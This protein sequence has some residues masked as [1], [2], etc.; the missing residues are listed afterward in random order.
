[1]RFTPNCHLPAHTLL[2]AQNCVVIID[3]ITPFFLEPSLDPIHFLGSLLSL[4]RMSSKPPTT[5]VLT[6]LAYS[7]I[8]SHNIDIPLP[9]KFPH[10]PSAQAL[11]SQIST[12]VI[13][14]S[15]YQHHLIRLEAESKALPDPIHLDRAKDGLVAALGSNA[16]PLIILALEYRKKSGRAIKET[17]TLDIHSS[18]LSILD[19]QT[20][21][22]QAPSGID[23]GTTFNLGMTDRQRESKEEVVLPHFSAQAHHAAA[24][25]DSA[26]DIEYTL[27]AED[28]FD[29]EEDV[30]E[31][32][33]I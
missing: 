33:L 9:L 27:D 23:F 6:F 11:L 25:S 29:D 3:S 26:A 32:L 10:Y 4:Q 24:T 15:S 13:S 1:M 21:D 8:L 16:T 14:L 17:C 28:D 5:P 18:K 7:V 12:A 2:G 20:M 19:V 22:D 31:D 30:D